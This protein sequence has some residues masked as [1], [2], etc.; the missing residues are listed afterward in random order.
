MNV[1]IV[2]ENM[3]LIKRLG[4]SSWK[5][6]GMPMKTRTELL[7]KNGKNL[8]VKLEWQLM[9]RNEKPMKRKRGW[10]RKTGRKRS[11]NRDKEMNLIKII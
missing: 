2:I 9:R 6:T 4:S 11:G 1:R 5:M 3:R 7:E 8:N 10:R